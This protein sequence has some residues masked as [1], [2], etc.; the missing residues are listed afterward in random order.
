MSNR[1]AKSI[2][3][4]IKTRDVQKSEKLDKTVRGE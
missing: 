3:E 4:Q 2:V 1:I